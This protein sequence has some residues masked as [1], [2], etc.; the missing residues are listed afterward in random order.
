M[1]VTAKPKKKI[2]GI[3]DA[4][5]YWGLPIEMY[6][7]GATEFQVFWADQ[8]LKWTHTDVKKIVEGFVGI[9]IR[10]GFLQSFVVFY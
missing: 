5:E 4:T 10:N 8:G 7:E 9:L 1:P 2:I 6:T 3:V